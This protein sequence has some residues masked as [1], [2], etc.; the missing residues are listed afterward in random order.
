MELKP[1]TSKA[2]D[3]W[4]GPETWH[5]NHALDMRRFYDFVDRYSAEHGTIIDE[6]AVKEE[7]LRRLHARGNATEAMERIIEM[8]I[9]LALNILDFLKQSGR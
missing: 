5:T 1:E 2:L 4:L 9:S 6:V 8:R 7:V 3:Q